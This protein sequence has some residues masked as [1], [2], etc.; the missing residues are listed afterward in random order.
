MYG[1]PIPIHAKLMKATNFILLASQRTGTNMLKRVL[2]TDPRVFAYPE[3]FN[4]G[5]A[6]T[7]RFPEG[8]SYYFDYKEA[9]VSKHPKHSH[10]D[11]AQSLVTDYLKLIEENGEKNDQ[12]ALIDI[13][14]NSLHHAN[15]TWH[16]P[17]DT[18]VMLKIFSSH[19]YPVVHLQRRNILR[20][21][22]SH[23]RAAQT[24]Q[25]ALTDEK[26]VKRI[27]LSVDPAQILNFAEHL[28]NTREIITKHLEL[29]GNPCLN[30]YYEDL[31]IEG[32]GSAFSAEQFNRISEFMGIEAPQFDLNPRTVKFAPKHIADE[33][34]NFD[35]LKKAIRRTRF[36]KQLYMP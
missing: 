14:Y 8:I 20:V 9:A 6:G 17:L 4:N 32:P 26:D 16:A 35:D 31:F 10:P 28:H 27:K 3:V 12:R 7:S 33:I 1:W 34:E 25:Y 13:K 30:L 19:H 23:F 5:S 24:N 21:A 18:P 22:I 15:G 36:K 2:E 11:A 29:I